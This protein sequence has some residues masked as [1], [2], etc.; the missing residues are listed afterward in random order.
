MR[1]AYRGCG[2]TK[3]VNLANGLCPNCEST[4][5]G[6]GSSRRLEQQQSRQ[7]EARSSSFDESRGLNNSDSNTQSTDRCSGEVINRNKSNIAVPKADVDLIALNNSY[8]EMLSSGDQPKINTEMFG[9]MLNVLTRLT[10]G[11][12]VK[13]KVTNNEARISELERKVGDQSVISERL[14]IVIRNLPLPAVGTSKLDNVRGALNYAVAPGV[15]TLTDVVK[16]MR[17]RKL[18]WDS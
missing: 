1:C 15:H 9:M 5:I 11:D 8:Q 13:E 12:S 17:V 14:G 18:S 6:S 2:R 7:N 3:N 4:I 16:A 10:E